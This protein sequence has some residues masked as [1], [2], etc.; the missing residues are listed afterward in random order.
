M[1]MSPVLLQAR[2][3]AGLVSPHESELADYIGSDDSHQSSLLTS[4]WYFSPPRIV[5]GLI[6]LGN[7]A[8]GVER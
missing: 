7:D 8:A 1:R 6:R 3:R 2:Q 5:E 4:Q